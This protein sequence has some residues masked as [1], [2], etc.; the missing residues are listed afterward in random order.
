MFD[1][2]SPR[3]D[4]LNHLLSFGLDIHWRNHLAPFLPKRSSLKI[5]DLATGTADALISLCQHNRNVYAGSGI[6]LADK[7]LAIGREKIKKRGLT[8]KLTLTHGDAQKIPFEDNTF[9]AA[10][11][12]FGIRNTDNPSQVLTEMLRVLTKKGRAIILEFS[13]PENKI[14]RAH[15]SRLERCF[16]LFWF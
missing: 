11:I 5:L 2:I 10:A 3:Y 7:M 8:R 14:L 9:D 15:Y 1:E 12:A 6:D 4:F 16:V 13:L